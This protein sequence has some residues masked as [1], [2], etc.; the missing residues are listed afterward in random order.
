MSELCAGGASRL[1]LS[2]ALIEALEV[3]FTAASMCRDESDEVN[4]NLHLFASGRCEGV[5][6]KYICIFS[7]S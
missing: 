2:S 1:M 3:G 4:D 5:L 7:T 6:V